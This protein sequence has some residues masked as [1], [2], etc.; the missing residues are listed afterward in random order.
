[1][2]DREK[3]I[4]T[5]SHLH[6][7]EETLTEVL[8]MTEQEKRKKRTLGTTRRGLILALAAALLLALGV[9]AY[10]VGQ[11]IHGVHLSVS[12]LFAFSYCLRSEYSQ[13]KNTEVICRSILQWT[14]FCQNSPP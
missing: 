7:S 9:T 8:R 6:A 14:T 5:F 3:I 12:Y 10:A 11:S 4:R 1:M 2:T 13:G